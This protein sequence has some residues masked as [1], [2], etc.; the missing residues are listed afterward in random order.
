MLTN[1]DKAI[2]VL[3]SAISALIVFMILDSSVKIVTSLGIALLTYLLY[4]RFVLHENVRLLVKS[5]RRSARMLFFLPVVIYVFSVVLLSGVT[6]A[7]P[8]FLDWTSISLVNWLKLGATVLLTTVLP[9]YFVLSIFDS[10]N[11]L[12]KTSFLAL[13][14]LVS[15]F[16]SF[17]DFFF[18]H[19]IGL[20][21]LGRSPRFA[22]RQRRFGCLLYSYFDLCWSIEIIFGAKAR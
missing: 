1:L 12:S 20:F 5:D 4:S 3:A 9:G 22:N 14:P 15:I 16:F 18:H 17:V 2:G 8:L 6:A 13:V 10:K 21:S 19:A 7:N 11:E